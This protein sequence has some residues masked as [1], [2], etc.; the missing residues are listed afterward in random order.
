MWWS[1]LLRPHPTRRPDGSWTVI[2][3]EELVLTAPRPLR[4]DPAASMADDL[5]ATALLAAHVHADGPPV[6][7]AVAA[8]AVLQRLTEAG[9]PRRFQAW[10]LQGLYHL[11]AGAEACRAQRGEAVVSAHN[12]RARS[13]LRLAATSPDPVTARRARTALVRLG[14]A[15]AA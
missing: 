5:R 1:P 12:V 8:A 2:E 10:L 4:D 6:V 14:A 7:G 13:I 11:L 3:A 9:D 15:V